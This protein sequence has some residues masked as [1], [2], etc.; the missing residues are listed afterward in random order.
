[1][2]RKVEEQI[3]YELMTFTD[4]TENELMHIVQTRSEYIFIPALKG[5]RSLV[6]SRNQL[7]WAQGSNFKSLLPDGSFKARGRSG[8]VLDTIYVD[9]V[10]W[11][12]DVLLWKDCLLLYCEAETRSFWLTVNLDSSVGNV[13]ADNRYSF[14]VLP[15][16]DGSLENWTEIM[17]DWIENENFDGILVYNKHSHYLS[18]QISPHCWRITKDLWKYCEF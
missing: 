4:V 10:F 9:D 1:M 8:V 12:L 2:S 11:V 7:T 16:V 15:R 5:K 6:F 3:D 18:G 14:Q 13:T 17:K